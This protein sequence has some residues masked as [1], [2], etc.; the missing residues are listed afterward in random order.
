M[1]ASRRSKREIRN[2]DDSSDMG[3]RAWQTTGSERRDSGLDSGPRVPPHNCP[4]RGA[5]RLTVHGPVWTGRVW[6]VEGSLEQPLRWRKPQRIF[7]NSMSDLFH[8][9]LALIDI[10][11]VFD[12]MLRASWHGFQI[13]TK[14]AGR[15]RELSGQLP[16][17]PHIWMGVSVE[18]ADYVD[19]IDE[20]RAT[21]AHIKL[22]SLEPLLGPLEHL[23]L[24]GIDWI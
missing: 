1:K 3:E 5:T 17:A 4:A 15:L 6:L 23:D 21:G 8:A 18:N 2:D 16:W 10:L 24:R 11:K 13:L 14:R 12:V 19:R 20:L 22:L 7:V 9:T